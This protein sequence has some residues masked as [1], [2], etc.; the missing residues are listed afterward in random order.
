MLQVALPDRGQP[1]KHPRQG[2]VSMSIEERATPNPVSWVEQDIQ[3]YIASDGKDNRH[4]A[5]ENLIL[6]Y[7]TG[8]TSGEIRRV[9][10]GSFPSEDGSRLVAASNGGHPSEPMWYRN[11]LADDRVWVRK[12]ADLYEARATVLEPDERDALWS[13]ITARIPVM[14][15]MQDKAGRVIPIVRLARSAH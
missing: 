11:L 2:D 13:E 4:P 12:Q 7:T 5:G 10:L 1:N 9:A 6:L 8:R 3:T 15:Q 14:Q